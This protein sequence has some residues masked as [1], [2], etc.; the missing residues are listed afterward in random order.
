MIIPSVNYRG[1]FLP[2]PYLTNIFD[3]PTYEYLYQMQLELKTNALSVHSN[4][5]GG[6]HGHIVLLMTN[7]QYDLI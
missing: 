4:I 3:I 1:N 5:G 7:A 2:K 6:T